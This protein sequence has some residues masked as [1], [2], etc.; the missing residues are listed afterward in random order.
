MQT[1]F[2]DEAGRP[3]WSGQAG[4]LEVWYLTATDK[5]TGAGLWIHHEVV[6]PTAGSAA[7]AHGWISWFPADR[8]EPPRTERFGPTSLTPE[9]LGA[10][11]CWHRGAGAAIGPERLEG[12]IGSM[13]WELALAPG[14]GPAL[15]TFPRSVWSR[16]LLPGAQV[17]PV[18]SGR[19]I[20]VVTVDGNEHRFD[21]RAGLAHI[22]GHGNAQRWCWLHAD[23]GG[24]DVLE[25]VSA[26][27]RRAGLRRVPPLA[28]VQLRADGRDWPRH[29]LAAAPLVRTRILDGGF[30]VRGVIG[31]RRLRIDAALP[32]DRSVVLDYVDPD[33]APA[34]CTNTEQASVDV[35]I[36]TWAGRWKP[37]HSWTLDGTAHAEIG[38]RP[39]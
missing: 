18:P 17:V 36:E 9:D 23:L 31:R 20:G 11:G 1:P 30:T 35:R 34:R 33:G 6:S 28:M 7:H 26:T 32:R 2:T 10:G 5:A 29:P 15:Y 37:L 19:L 24:G 12:Q 38:D 21:G 4:R 13:T 27:A 39:A 8:D 25:L 14:D 3:R 16:E 22:W